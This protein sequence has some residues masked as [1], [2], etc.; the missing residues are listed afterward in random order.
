MVR[1]AFSLYPAKYYRIATALI[2]VLGAFIHS[3]SVSP[4]AN[5][6]FTAAA[7]QDPPTVGQILDVAASGSVGPL[8]LWS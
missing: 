8:A 3:W 6:N 7:N 1:Q 5:L 2:V 4:S